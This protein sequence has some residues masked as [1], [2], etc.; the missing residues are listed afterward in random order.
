MVSESRSGPDVDPGAPLEVL[1][2]VRAVRNGCEAVLEGRMM[3]TV[4]TLAAFISVLSKAMQWQAGRPPVDL[5]D[6]A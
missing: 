4:D 2:R 5:E 6:V 1:D 3:P